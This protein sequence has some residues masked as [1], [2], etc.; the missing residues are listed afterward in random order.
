[1]SSNPISRIRLF[2]NIAIVAVIVIALTGASLAIGPSGY[3]WAYVIGGVSIAVA[4]ASCVI[5][6]RY[7][8][9]IASAWDEQNSHAHRDSL[10]FGYWVV[11]WIFVIMVGLTLTERLDPA[12]AFYWLGPVLAAVPPTH[13][14]ISVARGRAE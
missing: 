13:F 1:M 11:L 3:F 14:L 7:P 4:I 2:G 8:R 9:A 6:L 10:V 12:T 5:H